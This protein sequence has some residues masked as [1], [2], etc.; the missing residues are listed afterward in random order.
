VRER[1]VLILRRA[2]RR[3]RFWQIERNKATQVHR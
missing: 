2:D 1:G 3:R